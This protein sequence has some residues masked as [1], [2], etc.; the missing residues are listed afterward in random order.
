[1]LLYK[2][3]VFGIELQIPESGHL[4]LN[5]KRMMKKDLFERSQDIQS[6]KQD[7]DRLILAWLNLNE[8]MTEG[9][10]NLRIQKFVIRITGINANIGG[11]CDKYSLTQ[12]GDATRY[13]E[14]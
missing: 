5:I 3:Y 12:I 11:F 1:M 7:R 6:V 14:L 4:I 2:S 8:A 9:K 13:I 10:D